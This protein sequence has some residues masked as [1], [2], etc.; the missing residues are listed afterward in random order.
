MHR[1]APILLL[2]LLLGASSA[3]GQDGASRPCSKGAFRQFDFW[4]G[5]WEVRD[6]A[7]KRA[8]ENTISLEHNGCVL[9]E[10]WASASGGTGMS[11]NHYDPQAGVWRQHWVGLGLILEMS[12][13]LKDGAMI[14][15][16]PLQYVGTD[17]V[18]LLRGVWTPLP[19]GRLRQHFLESSDEGKTWSEWFDGYYSKTRAARRLKRQPARVCVV[20]T[21]APLPAY[22]ARASIEGRVTAM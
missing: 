3:G 22:L 16:G 5:V 21:P 9:V 20:C 11:M 18:T 2:L 14:M 17:R 19:D 4:I 6:A 1:V 13:G 10:R 8:G 7:G 12:G 15:E